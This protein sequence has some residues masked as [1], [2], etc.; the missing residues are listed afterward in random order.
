MIS[1]RVSCKVETLIGND[2]ESFRLLCR[3]AFVSVLKIQIFQPW[4]PNHVFVI[5]IDVVIFVLLKIFVGQ[6]AIEPGFVEAK[7]HFDK[8][9]FLIDEK[10]FVNIK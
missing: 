1:K 6:E 5:L 3:F 7:S 9:L 2:Y 4:C 8:V 10:Y